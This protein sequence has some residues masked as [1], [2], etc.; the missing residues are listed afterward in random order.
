MNTTEQKAGYRIERIYAAEQS[1]VIVADPETPRAAVVVDRQISFN[2]DWRPVSPL[3]FEVAISLSGEP[4]TEIPEQI[5]VRIVGVFSAESANVNVPLGEFLRVNAPA[6]LFPFAR[7]VISTLT[8]R[9][10]FGTFHLNPV[11][12]PALLAGFDFSAS[13]GHRFLRERPEVAQG[14]GMDLGEPSS[15][16]SAP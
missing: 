3:R 12:V 7:E 15:S 5:A 6:I 9:G 10:P 14:F 13:T 11:N 16:A 1:Y 4:T 8:G 2:W